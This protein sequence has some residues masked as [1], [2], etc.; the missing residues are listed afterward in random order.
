MNVGAKPLHVPMTCATIRRERSHGA[1]Y[2]R[3][4]S[5]AG[6]EDDVAKPGLE[7]TS[8]RAIG[9]GTSHEHSVHD[10]AGDVYSRE[11]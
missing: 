10:V 7:S 9:E 4:R 8:K 1:A 3:T 2:E 5:R 11:L 6:A